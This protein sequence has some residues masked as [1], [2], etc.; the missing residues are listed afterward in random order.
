MI[1]TPGRL[2]DVLGNFFCMVSSNDCVFVLFFVSVF[3]FCFS[4]Q[5]TATLFFPNAHMSF[6]MK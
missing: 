5:K 6:W 1:A 2:I 4:Q 3:C